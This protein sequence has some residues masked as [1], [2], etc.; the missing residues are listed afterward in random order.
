MNHKQLVDIIGN[1][2]N[3]ENSTM[4][5]CIDNEV[6]KI[7]KKEYWLKADHPKEML[8]LNWKIKDDDDIVLKFNSN[9]SLESVMGN[10][11]RKMN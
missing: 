2:W 3:A 11:V 10:G 8:E 6:L 5:R 4:Q 7:K 9:I 1:A